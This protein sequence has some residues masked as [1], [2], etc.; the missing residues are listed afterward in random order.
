MEEEEQAHLARLEAHLA[1]ERVSRAEKIFHFTP[2]SQSSTKTL[3][4]ISM[5][6][7]VDYV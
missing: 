4:G 7:H 5:T 3:A 2:E 1:N 6:V